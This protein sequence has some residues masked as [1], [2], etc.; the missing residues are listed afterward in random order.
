M[1]DEN[2]LDCVGFEDE[3]GAVLDSWLEEK[4]Y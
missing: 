3:G 1:I 4:R 2:K